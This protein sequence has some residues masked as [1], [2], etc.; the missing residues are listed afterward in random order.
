MKRLSLFT[1][2]KDIYKPL[3]SKNAEIYFECI[4]ILQ[5]L[6]IRYQASLMEE[7]AKDAITQYLRQTAANLADEDDEDAKYS[8]ETNEIGKASVIIRYFRKVKWLSERELGSNGRNTVNVTSPCMKI[9]RHVESTFRE[10]NGATLANSLMD[11]YSYLAD[12]VSEGWSGRKD[13]P[14]VSAIQPVYDK[15]CDLRDKMA[16]LRNNISQ[17][18]SL[19]MQI[20]DLEGINLY[21][22]ND[23]TT[24]KIFEDYTYITKGGNFPQY[25]DEIRKKYRAI[26]NDEAIMEKIKEDASENGVEPDLLYDIMQTISEY[27]QYGYESD[28]Q[29]IDA[30]VNEYWQLYYARLSM[31]TRGQGRI[32]RYVDKFL[33]EIKDRPDRDEILEELMQKSFHYHS[34][35][36]I[37]LSSISGYIKNRRTEKKHTAPIH[38]K[39]LSEEEKSRQEKSYREKVQQ[40]YSE[41][42]TKE[43]LASILEK[44]QYDRSVPY[45]S[46]SAEDIKDKEDSLY[47]LNALSFQQL[48]GFPYSIY[49]TGKPIETEK[50]IMSGLAIK[51]KEE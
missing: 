34:Q 29:A 27:L 11:I 3:V 1:E 40:K 38:S 35:S 4:K 8:S 47:L 50:L 31:I 12:L 36:I 9:I 22:L 25:I 19:I 20:N 32:D 28:V 2:Y 7:E 13:R 39:N 46:I 49:E 23:V 16:S 10:N 15:M 33:L 24:K 43:K 44:H 45:V 26:Q 51:R 42:Q 18:R 5:N 21:S 37:C 6:E 14:Y 41:K 17:T 48:P 30:R